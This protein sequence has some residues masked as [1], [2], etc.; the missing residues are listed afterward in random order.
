MGSPR[1]VC[2]GEDGANKTCARARAQ[3]GGGQAPGVASRE[4]TPGLQRAV[5]VGVC[6]CWGRTRGAGV[7]FSRLLNPFCGAPPLPLWPRPIP[8][9]PP[10]ALWPGPP[11]LAPPLWPRPVPS[12]SA[13]PLWLRPC[14]P[15][16][17][18]SSVQPLLTPRSSRHGVLPGCDGEGFRLQ[19]ACQR[20]SD[21][22]IRLNAPT[23]GLLWEPSQVTILHPP[24]RPPPRGGDELSCDCPRPKPPP[25]PT[26]PH[27]A[28]HLSSDRE[29]WEDQRQVAGP[30]VTMMLWNSQSLL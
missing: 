15:W 5:R 2:L 4:P 1:G 11:P 28:R 13:L 30:S 29:R 3:R 24:C 12:G 18:A 23:V 9:A 25:A 21:E 16:R 7:V 19:K 8:L 10:H 14:G 6:R 17:T 20:R 22:T 27:S 26:R